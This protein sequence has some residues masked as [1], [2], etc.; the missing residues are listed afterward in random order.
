MARILII[1]DEENIRSSLK[2]ALGR[3]D[4]TVATAESLQQ[5]REFFDGAFDVIFL[6]VM[7]PDGNGLD[8]L[9]WMLK[10]DPRQTVVMI[11]GHA[12]IDTAVG[13]IRD[14]AYD[15][16]EKPISL[17]RVLVTIDNACKTSSL[18]TQKDR[19]S[20]QL[21]G[22]FI[23]ESESIRVLKAEVAKAAGR[24]DRFLVLGENG[25]GKELI[26]H[27]IHTQGQFA[28]GPFVAVN[29]AALPSELIE[30]ELFGHVG[31]AFTGAGKTR[32]GRFAE[33][34]GGSIFLDEISEMSP[35]AQAKILRVI[36]TR[37]VTPVGSDKAAT[38]R[39]NIIAASNRDLRQMIDEHKFREDLYHRLNV[40]SFQIPPLRERP[41]DIPLLAEHF[42][43]KFTSDTK[44]A[45]KSFS[46]RSLAELR[47]QHFTGNTR[48]LKNL[49][50]RINIYCEGPE[51]QPDDIR[52]F[53][54]G[55][56]DTAVRTLKE[57]VERFEKEQIESAIVRNNGNVAKAARELGLERSHL[58]KKMKRLGQA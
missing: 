58:Y 6:D 52:G 43:T 4:H 17:D 22:E 10:R 11:S 45:P 23:G 33:A 15:F 56:P 28:D 8:L 50:E 18:A 20:S 41:D 51:I 2:S 35:E 40:V 24:T 1:D 25:T 49:V 39:G 26:A 47:K 27:L 12:D 32:K 30:A 46:G 37:Q 21:Y 3:R 31:G 5:G 36:E 42:L 57:S 44:A 14:G 38:V 29:C 53:L 55:D 13:A 16:I 9:K 7:L 54:P 34:H 19:L 48:E